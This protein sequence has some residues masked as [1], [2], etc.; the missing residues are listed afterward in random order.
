MKK[1][2]KEV[3]NEMAG[4]GVFDNA[5]VKLATGLVNVGA[6]NTHMFCV[7][8]TV[9][10]TAHKDTWATYSDVKYIGA[11]NPFEINT[12]NGYTLG[13]GFDATHGI[14]M[15]VP[16]VTA[17]VTGLK[18]SAATVFTTTGTLAA[19]YAVTNWAVTA[20][21]LANTANSILSYHNI[22]A[23]SVTNGTLTLTW[24]AA[25]IFTLTVGADS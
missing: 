8:G 3:T 23:Q 17:A 14:A 16:T 19:S 18:T 15:S 13:G 2:R 7:L 20:S 5:M 22:G 6:A 12:V 25:G 1:T 9:A 10:P 24:N 11:G 4:N 21:D